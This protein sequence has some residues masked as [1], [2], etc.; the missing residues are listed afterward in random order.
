MAKQRFGLEPGSLAYYQQIGER[1]RII[2]TGVIKK[3]INRFAQG[4]TLELREIT[5]RFINGQING[6]E[7]YDESARVM[8]L[9]YRAAVDIARGDN[10][11]MDDNDN[12]EWLALALLLLLLLNRTAEALE[13]G[14]LVLDGRLMNIAGLRGG[15]VRSIFEN[16]RNVVARQTGYTEARR[17][18]GVAEHCERSADRPG[19]VELAARGWVPIWTMVPLGGATCR[20]NCKCTVQY[21]GMSDFT[22]G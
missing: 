12:E 4:V 21:R 5:N 19:C 10:G 18:L 1:R 20:D 3:D 9:S 15:G 14:T 6:Q 16:F 7:W 13:K 2:D 17:V 8:K 22:G 11:E